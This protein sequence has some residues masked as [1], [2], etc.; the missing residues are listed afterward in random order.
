MFII[1]VLS[2][3]SDTTTAPHED[4]NGYEKKGPRNSK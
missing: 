3:S 2:D 1:F 4:E